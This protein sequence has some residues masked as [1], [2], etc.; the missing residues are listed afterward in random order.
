MDNTA[1][2]RRRLTQAADHLARAATDLEALENDT[3]E[4]ERLHEAY[5]HAYGGMMMLYNRALEMREA[6]ME[7]DLGSLIHDPD[8]VENW[9]KQNPV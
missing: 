5:E 2:N 9:K 1:A 7:G 3:G 6:K 8:A 4:D